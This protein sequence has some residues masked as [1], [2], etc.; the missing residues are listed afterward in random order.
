MMSIV[1]CESGSGGAGGAS[2]A[3]P[4]TPPADGN[5][6]DPDP[7]PTPAPLVDHSHRNPGYGTLPTQSE[8]EMLKTWQIGVNETWMFGTAYVTAGETQAQADLYNQRHFLRLDH[9]G[10]VWRQWN[11]VAWTNQFLGHIIYDL[12]PDCSVEVMGSLTG[13]NRVWWQGVE[14]Q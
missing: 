4:T 9:D 14:I 2:G 1:A 8:C 11:G 6:N 13:V 5:S 7:T 3:A 12:G 10:I